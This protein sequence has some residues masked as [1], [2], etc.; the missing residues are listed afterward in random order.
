MER[1]QYP[2]FHVFFFFFLKLRLI[3]TQAPNITYV[4]TLF[5]VG[6]PGE[7]PKKNTI[8]CG[9]LWDSTVFYGFSSFLHIFA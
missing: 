9:F 2:R 1:R 8:A 7:C 5:S 4:T 6:S 3:E